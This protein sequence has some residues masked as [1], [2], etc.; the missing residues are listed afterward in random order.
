MLGIPQNY[1]KIERWGPSH[2]ARQATGFAAR[3]N[4]RLKLPGKFSANQPGADL[5]SNDSDSKNN[6]PLGQYPEIENKR[7]LH[8]PAGRALQIR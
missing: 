1:H 5:Q 7:H 4:L 8:Q 6:S 3:K 2:H